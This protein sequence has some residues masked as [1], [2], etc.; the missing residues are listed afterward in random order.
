MALLNP[1]QVVFYHPCDS[2]R[3]FT[4]GLDWTSHGTGFFVDA[5][6]VSGI[7]PANGS[8]YQLT[9]P[10]GSYASPSGATS[11]TFALWLQQGWADESYAIGWVTDA[12]GDPANGLKILVDK[13]PT[14]RTY[15]TPYSNSTGGSQNWIIGNI[16]G[17]GLLVIRLEYGGGSVS[18]FYSR[19]GEAWTALDAKTLAAPAATGN[20][21]MVGCDGTWA[22]GYPLDEVVLWKDAPIF[23]NQELSNLYSLG[24][25]YGQTMDHY[26]DYWNNTP[27]GTTE[28]FV[29][30]SD[31]A[32]GQ[33]PAIATGHALESG[34]SP[35]Y[36]AA[37]S[38]TSGSAP[39]T[40]INSVA[41]AEA[42][43]YLHNQQA[44]GTAD[45]YLYGVQGANRPMFLRA[46]EQA[47]S[48]ILPLSLYGSSGVTVGVKAGSVDLYLANDSLPASTGLNRPMFLKAPPAGSSSTTTARP[49][50]L[51]GGG[52]LH[53]T[54]NLYLQAPPLVSGEAG[55][56]VRGEGDEA[57]SDGYTPA[58]GQWSMFMRVQDGVIAESPLSITGFT[59]P[60]GTCDLNTFGILGNASSTCPASLA[61]YKHVESKASLSVFG[62]M[63]TA[64]GTSPLSM[65]VSSSGVASGTT[66]LYIHAY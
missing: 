39:L 22:Q 38:G 19:N 62:I 45:L 64:S 41:Q 54:A 23:S 47:V 14:F 46:S 13:E 2:V 44:I 4:K 61:G 48:S 6:R 15:V 65:Q 20:H 32:S 29:H 37:P 52:V 18:G 1:D 5:V 40:L 50:F 51:K 34:L 31:S 60:S 7:K 63:G 11:L 27:S 55:L 53:A 16:S 9:Y 28:L 12:F 24:L 59:W 36:I 49:M 35:L 30:G 66:A 3:E 42:P 56:F 8:F 25:S 43:L 26:S 10:S 21:V 33:A 57:V 58:S 17:S